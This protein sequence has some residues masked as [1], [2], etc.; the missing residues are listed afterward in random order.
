MPFLS[1]INNYFAA[2]VDLLYPRTCPVC[3]API[4][5]ADAAV[6]RDCVAAISF[7]EQPVCGRCGRHVSISYSGAIGCAACAGEKLIADRVIALGIYEGGLKECIHAFK[8][9]R[10]ERLG[11]W[12]AEM[13]VSSLR[14]NQAD[15]LGYDLVVP[16]PMHP[17]KRKERGFNQAEVM[18]R[19]LARLLAIPCNPG[20]IR[21]NVRGQ[22]Q[23]S[24]SRKDR[25]QNVAGAFQ[26][27]SPNS[28]RGRRVLLVDDI[29]TT[30]ATAAA[31][32]SLLKHSGAREIT[33]LVAA[34]GR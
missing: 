13:M 2:C 3:R 9:G 7:L 20:V 21:R 27:A 12:V 23:S 32:S 31:C 19:H 14:R 11:A 18:S 33:V 10:K 8:F 34:R 29:F 28:V 1:A 24:L 16:V 26:C 6:C 5:S 15:M 25:F 4:D 17:A 22:T 30:G